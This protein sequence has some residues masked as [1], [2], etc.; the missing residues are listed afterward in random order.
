MLA[1]GLF[2]LY[3]DNPVSN[4]QLSI[5]EQA[6]LERERH[7]QAAIQINELAGRIHSEGDAVAF[8]NKLADFLADT[9]PPDWV[10]RSVRQRVARAEYEAVSNPLQL[11]P[12]QRIAD[13]WNKYVRE[14]GAS[15]EALVTAAEIH[16]LRDADFAISQLW[17]S[18]QTNQIIWTMPNVYAVDPDGKVAQ[19][20]RGVETLRV[21]YDLDMLFDNLRSARE[22]V[23]RG[24]LFS[25]ELRKSLENPP[26]KEKTT[27]R[28]EARVETNPLRPA[29]H[30]YMQEHGPYVLNSVMEKLFDE[31]FPQTTR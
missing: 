18:R 7:R 5:Q 16:N 30:R 28:L 9:L 27:A 20:C 13:V 19:G 25:E 17:W 15:D 21:L 3:Q 8:V 10:T 24:T 14:M 6:K 23:R 4:G 26:R 29:E 11:I 12:E 2:A 1:L 31:L 22:T